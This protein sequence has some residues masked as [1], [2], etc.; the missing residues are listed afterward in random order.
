M[1]DPYLAIA[2]IASDQHMLDRMNAAATQEAYRDNINTD[3]NDPLVWVS[4]NRYVWAASPTWGEKWR[5]AQTVNETDPNYEPGKDE[6]VIT[7]ADILSTV[8]T[9]MG[10]AAREQAANEAPEDER[11]SNTADNVAGENA[12]AE[13][14]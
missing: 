6:A 4:T 7:D 12:A 11:E 2:E 1:A 3:P 10:A 8:Q 9:Y 13:S 14:G 5:Y